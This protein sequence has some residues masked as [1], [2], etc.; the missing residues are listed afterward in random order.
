MLVKNELPYVCG[1]MAF[2]L[3]AIIGI[4]YAMSGCATGY[5]LPIPAKERRIYD[6]EERAW[7]L[8]HYD[9]IGTKEEREKIYGQIASLKAAIAKEKAEKES[10]KHNNGKENK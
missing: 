4:S 9:R 6:L 1:V 2:C 7:K 5:G 8:E 3:A 10:E